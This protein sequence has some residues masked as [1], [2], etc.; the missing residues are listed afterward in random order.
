MTE[1]EVNA[2]DSV[3]KENSGEVSFPHSSL[4]SELDEIRISIEEIPSKMREEMD[5]HRIS[6]RYKSKH[7]EALRHELD[8]VSEKLGVLSRRQGVPHILDSAVEETLS[9]RGIETREEWQNYME[10]MER[11]GSI[12][13]ELCDELSVTALQLIPTV[14]SLKKAALGPQS[15][16]RIDHGGKH[17]SGITDMDS[18]TELSLQR[19]REEEPPIGARSRTSSKSYVDHSAKGAARAG[20]DANICL[21]NYVQSLS[22]PDPGV[23]KGKSNENFDEFI[24]KFRRK[25]SKVVADDKSLIEMLSDNHLG[26]RAKS[27]MRALPASV[28]NK[29]FEEVVKNLGRLLSNDCVAWRM[30]ALTELRTLRMRPGQSVAEFCVVLED[31]GRK[32][33]PDSTEEA[34]SLENA[35]ILLENLHEW[36]EYVHLMS[37]LNR[38]SPDR[39]YDE[40]KQLV[41]GIEQSKTL[42]RRKGF[43]PSGWKSRHSIYAQGTEDEPRNGTREEDAPGF[44]KRW[45]GVRPS[46]PS[47]HGQGSGVRAIVE[48]A[49]KKCFNCARPGQFARECPRKPAKVQN[50]RKENVDKTAGKAVSDIIRKVRSCNVKTHTQSRRE[51]AQAIGKL[52]RRNIRLLGLTAP[53]LID[54]GSMVSIIPI[55]LLEKAQEKGYEVDTLPTLTESEVGPVYD[56]SG[57]EMEIVGAV[58]VEAEL[59]GG[60]RTKLVL[61]ITPLP[62]DEVLLGMNALEKLGVQISITNGEEDGLRW[63]SDSNL[64]ANKEAKVIRRTY[65]PSRAIAIVEVDCEGVEADERILWTRRKDVASGIFKICNQ[66]ATIPVHNCNE[67]SIVLKEGETVGEWST[68]KWNGKLEDTNHLML[69]SGD[70]TMTREQKRASMVEQLKE[71]MGNEEMDEEL[72]EV[73][74]ENE[75]AF[76]VS[77]KELSRTSLTEMDI[78]TGDNPPVKL[79]ARPVPLSIRPMLKELLEDLQKRS[80]IEKSSSPWAFPI[81]LVEKKDGSLRLC[82]DYRE[83]NK[84]I[85]QDPYPLPTIE[86]ILQ[87]LAGKKFFS[88]LDLCSGYW[89]IPLSEKA[90]EKSAFTTPEGLFQFK[91]TPFGLSTSPAVF[92]RLMDNVLHDL[93]GN[94]IFC[95]IDDI[96]ICTETRAR[97]LELLSK[98]CEK[99][100]KA[101]LRLKAKKCVLLQTKVA[102]LGHLIDSEGVHMD[103]NKVMAVE[104]YPTPTNVK[105]MRTF[106]G[107]ASYYRKFCLGFSKH[108]GILFRLTAAKAKWAWTQ[109]HEEA[110]KR[111]KK[112]ICSA[113]VLAQPDVEAAK[114]GKRPFVICTDASTTGLGAVLSQEGE[115]GYLHPIFFASKA[116]SKAERRYHVTDLEALAVVF[117]LRRFHMFIYG[118]PTTVMTDHQPLTAL[119]QRSNVSTRILRWSLEVQRY[120]LQIKYVKGK[121]NVIADALSRGAAKEPEETLIG[122]SAVVNSVRADEKTKWRVELEKDPLFAEVIECLENGKINGTVRLPGCRIPLRMA[123]FDL[124]NGELMLYQQDGSLVFVVPQN[125]RYEIFLEAHSG[126]FGGHFSANK[127][128]RILSKQVFWPN[129]TQDV[130][131]W[132]NECQKCFV[133][134]PRRSVI[135]PLKP[136]VTRSPYEMIGIDILELGLT[137]RGNKYAVTVIDVFSKFA[138]AYPVPDKSARTVAQTLFVR[139]IAEG[140]RWPKTILSDR[141]GE[142]ENKVLEEITEIAKIKHTMTKGYN[143]RENGVT[144]RMNATILAMLRKSTTVP[145]DWDVR[146]PFCMMAYNM[147]PHSATGESPYFILHG[148]DPNF[149]SDIIPRMEQSQYMVDTPIDDYRSDLLQGI[150]EVHARVRDHNNRVRESMKRMYDEKNKVNAN[151]HPKIGDRVYVQS[152]K[153]KGKSSHPKLVSEWA[154]PFRVIEVSENS[155]LV[156][157]IG[158]NSEPMRIQFDMLKVVPECISDERI[159]T[160]TSRGKR[161]RKKAVQ[162]ARSCKLTTEYFSGASLLSPLEKGH[163]LYKCS[164]GCLEGATLGDIEGVSFPGA[165]AKEEVGSLWNAWLACSIFRRR[166]ID[167]GRK[168]R[169]HRE[170]HVCGDASSLQ[171]VLKFAYARCIDWTDFICNT[172]EIADH[173]IIENQ[174]VRHVYTEALRKLREDIEERSVKEEQPKKGPVLYVSFEGANPME[175]DG[176]RGGIVTKVVQGFDH[177]VRILQDWN[178][179]RTWVI[180]WPQDSNLKKSTVDD[181]IRVIKDFME[182]G[183]VVI[184]A[185]PPITSRNHNKWFS[186]MD[187][188][189]HL[190]EA[191]RKLD[192]KQ[193]FCTASSK[194]FD[195][196]LFIEAGAPEGSAQFYS[197]YVGTSLP[198]QVYEAVR[199]RVERAKLPKIERPTSRAMSSRGEGMSDGPTWGRKRR[200]L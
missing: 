137:T 10:T 52:M 198:K 93:L 160:Q 1:M 74:M 87:S 187:M 172:K 42:F 147:T 181:L 58:T 51:D 106:L 183:G 102:F 148:R 199:Y 83:L 77:E 166:D 62:Q 188:W 56:A 130:H 15:E 178:S 41:L 118:L 124:V 141:G 63:K 30:R 25:Y 16:S 8:K 159:D 100:R 33:N 146:L 31:L 126:Q 9:T 69:D 61:H 145:T 179:A 37:T 86:A 190:D 117:A 105:E 23:F 27:T 29:G 7:E 28:V 109:E 46:L 71:N 43:G 64:T 76:A 175:R 38:A 60:R 45:Q 155:A 59:E 18:Y 32:A 164:D 173:S 174:D 34:R 67:A 119:F 94:E 167:V 19:R 157:R 180:V 91:V 200:A 136:M 90:K 12:L 171:L 193:A 170:G 122:D 13:T 57:N 154:G 11:D 70:A 144:E 98:V 189:K 158:E 111:V 66:R 184:S 139:W 197:N 191:L 97:H 72:M 40:I 121:A 88:T 68:E 149:P 132:T 4:A 49:G 82:V 81:V 194:I 24:R 115:D 125:S 114:N 65:V 89:Q 95:Y 165:V 104:R 195:G 163:L 85:K 103:P 107:M 152:P 48:E 96:I 168:I 185:W 110:F 182:S 151:R 176:V 39:A 196:K 135:P 3:E 113:P 112:M 17:E 75:D 84:R 78:D 101:G 133:H 44:K 54:S 142:F 131:R 127:L 134:N 123:D 150:E 55:N 128:L 156:T 47:L 138:A 20:Q 6:A 50:L 14:K 2:F 169:L 177:L 26:G 143:P 140:C 162:Q 92:Q 22:C 36:P 80:I 161:G 21:L 186:M 73:L 53:A 153:E 116:L 99:L 192:D 129:M 5:E 79:K 108:A 35:Q 120:N